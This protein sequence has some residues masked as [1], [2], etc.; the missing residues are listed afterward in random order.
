MPRT[1]HPLLGLGVS[2]ALANFLW[3]FKSN[4][5][6]LGLRKPCWFPLW[7]HSLQYLSCLNSLD[8]LVYFAIR[9]G[10]SVFRAVPFRLSVHSACP[11]PWTST[12]E[13]HRRIVKRNAW[14][15]SP[16]Q[17]ICFISC[18]MNSHERLIENG[19]NDP[20]SHSRSPGAPGTRT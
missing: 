18:G 19:P 2:Q 20:Q 3:S 11:V 12:I 15:I 5:F 13:S 6:L 10:D 17:S 14:L 1:R 7:G 9:N 16:T 4:G 8:Q